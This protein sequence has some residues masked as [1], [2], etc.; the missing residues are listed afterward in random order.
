MNEMSDNS[1]AHLNEQTKNYW[2]EVLKRSK[3][4]IVL[5]ST[6]FCL[7]NSDYQRN[8]DYYL[9]RL[10]VQEGGVNLVCKTNLR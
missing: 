10:K 7:D 6:M 8:S 4:K 3:K 5:E 2:S 9:T 1:Q